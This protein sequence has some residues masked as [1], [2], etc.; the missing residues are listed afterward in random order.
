MAPIELPQNYGYVVG[1]L[2][3]VTNIIIIIIIVIII[4]NHHHH[5]HHHHHHYVASSFF[6]NTYLSIN[7][8]MARKKY[9][10]QYPNLYKVALSEKDQK[11]TDAFNSIQRAHQNTLVSY[12]ILSFFIYY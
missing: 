11:E 4:I 12:S 3:K 10:V 8:A 5:H 6:M 1:V 7:V 2:G 9:N